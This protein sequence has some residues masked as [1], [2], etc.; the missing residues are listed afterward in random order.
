VIRN[1]PPATV[2]CLL[3]LIAAGAGAAGLGGC[4]PY[5][6]KPLTAE[7]VARELA[8]PSNDAL[9]VA[10]AQIHH[11]IL[12]PM[13]LDLSQPISPEQAGVIAVILNPE[14]RAD[15]DARKLAAAQLLQAGLLPN[16]QLTGGI[17]FAYDTPP[18]DN[19]NAYTI[20]LNWDITALIARDAKRRAATAEAASVDL[21]VA[22][23]EWQVAQAARTAAY[24]V[25]ALQGQLAAARDADR[26]LAENLALVRRAFDQHQKTL[27][28]LAAA[29]ASA[30]EAH[31][32][33][34]AQQKDLEHQRLQLKRSIGIA[35][36]RPLALRDAPE[37][38][39]RLD[40]PSAEQLLAQLEDRRLD[41]LALKRGY[42][43]QDAT[44]RAAVLAQFP[45]INLGFNLARD[46]SDSKSFGPGASI[47]LPIFDR[48]QGAI[49]TEAA[50]RE[51]LFDEYVNRIFTARSDVAIALADLR[52]I[53]EQI[54]AAE[55]ALPE[56]ENLVRTVREA[57]DRGS[58]DVFNLSAARGAL[59]QKRIDVVKLKQ[60]LMQTWIALEIAS[61][62]YLPLPS[63]S[64]SAPT[65]A[66]TTHPETQ[67]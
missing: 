67:P 36:Q 11:P 14:L 26:Q 19:F 15:R 22:W 42:E 23:K 64:T 54:A 28:D 9:R 13:A 59:Y 60:Q 24:D 31:A 8:T 43:S 10:T 12:G 55:A 65:T 40:P 62:Q 51:K 48:N 32:A 27:L 21:D 39:S 38:P 37:L 4:Q 17:D 41:L 57:V 34:I 2:V 63:P 45:K 30:Q 16:P 44:L 61:G 5:R 20:G 3:A 1:I 58:L 66:S 6:A 7:V 33:V 50:T 18:P 46:N 25:L 47:D 56:L 35:P 53:D 29:Q 52:A 49:A